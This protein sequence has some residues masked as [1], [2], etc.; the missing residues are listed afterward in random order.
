LVRIIFGSIS[1][2]LYKFLI[3]WSFPVHL[4]INLNY[5][6]I[7]TFLAGIFSGWLRSRSGSIIPSSIGHGCFD[8]IVYGDLSILPIWVWA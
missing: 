3:I 2:T 1:H 7:F 4:D 5:L 8:I 6:T